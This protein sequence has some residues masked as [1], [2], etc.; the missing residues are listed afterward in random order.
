M[1]FG[2][3]GLIFTSNCLRMT[4]SEI[5]E[6]A[7]SFVRFLEREVPEIIKLIA[8]LSGIS[9]SLNLFWF[10]QNQIMLKQ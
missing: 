6:L 1:I 4:N 7:A 2:L 9:L 10:L 8:D 3:G 5:E